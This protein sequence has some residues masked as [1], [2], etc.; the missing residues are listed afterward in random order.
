M[1]VCGGWVF[2][3]VVCGDV[4]VDIHIIVGVRSLAF[5]GVFMHVG[6]CVGM[7]GMHSYV[8]DGVC[9][10]VCICACVDV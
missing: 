2:V 9:G 6:V 7:Q 5:A 3:V 10:S 1:C 8:F 4:V